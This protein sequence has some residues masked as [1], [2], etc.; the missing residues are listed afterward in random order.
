MP[1]P[2]LHY[3]WVLPS[4]FADPW[5]VA[6]DDMVTQMDVAVHS[7]EVV[8]RPRATTVISL[9]PA[10]NMPVSS[11]TAAAT[12][13]T[14]TVLSCSPYG[15]WVGSFSLVGSGAHVALSL[16][17][18]A[19][20]QGTAGFASATAGALRLRGIAARTGASSVNVT[21]NSAWSFAFTDI[22]NRHSLAFETVA[23]LGPGNYT[24]ELQGR[25]A[26]NT[27]ATSVAIF[28]TGDPTTLVAYEVSLE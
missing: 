3:G 19:F 21:G 26:D 11:A 18:S 2:T 1:S 4:E 27:A 10:T 22:F 28:G 14:W 17:S 8:S 13:G 7:V 12:G 9:A 20:L 25:V 24:L 6:L 5:Y 16:R 23:S 15:R